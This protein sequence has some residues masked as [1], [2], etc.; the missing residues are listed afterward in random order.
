MKDRQMAVH[1]K[2]KK[3][4]KKKKTPPTPPLGFKHN[5]KVQECTGISNS[6]CPP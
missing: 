3:E 6:T 2:K 1:K 5:F 4:R